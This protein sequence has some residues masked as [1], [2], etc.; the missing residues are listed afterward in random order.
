MINPTQWFK[1]FTT[2]ETAAREA[3]QISEKTR[4]VFSEHFHISLPSST[5]EVIKRETALKVKPLEGQ[6]TTLQHEL[7][8]AQAND[9]T[10]KAF[11]FLKA[12]FTLSMLAGAILGGMY[13]SGGMIALPVIF[14]SL[15]FLFLNWY[16]SRKHVDEDEADGLHFLFGFMIPIWEAFT[17]ISRIEKSLLHEERHLNYSKELTPAITNALKNQEAQL[18]KALRETLVFCSVSKTWQPIIEA[19]LKEATDKAEKFST[20][21]QPTQEDRNDSLS[22]RA[23]G[24]IWIPR[25]YRDAVKEERIKIVTEVQK[26]S[27]VN[28]NLTAVSSYFQAN[29]D[30]LTNLLKID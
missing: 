3:P 15:G 26:W 1:E 20:D 21:N 14:G 12:A 29:K 8:N 25:N 24:T 16:Y 13:L 27:Y 5:V 4:E 2:I 11:A 18:Q 7:K 19:Q 9:K 10:H 28:Q 22:V 23:D 30:R 6:V 17:K